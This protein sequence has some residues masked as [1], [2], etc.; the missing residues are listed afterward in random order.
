MIEKTAATAWKKNLGNLSNTSRGILEN[1][2]VLNYQKE[3][4]GL[5]K[6]SDNLVKKLGIRET[7]KPQ[8]IKDGISSYINRLNVDNKPGLIEQH[9]AGKL[10]N[11]TVLAGPKGKNIIAKGNAR[12]ARWMAEAENSM[13]MPG[14]RGSLERRH[15]DQ[16]IR[17]HEIDEAR[18]HR[19]LQNKGQYVK[20]DK[21]NDKNQREFMYHMS[22]EVINRESAN[23]AVAPKTTRDFFQNIR[24]ITGEPTQFKR[25]DP[26]F[27]YGKQGV[28][29][30]AQSN[31]MENTLMK[32]RGYK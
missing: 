1:K 4:Q 32:L 29:N 13:P 21:G 30:K 23:V 10:R 31:Q 28:F 17:R 25:L 19:R 3:F 22:P 18:V 11:R 26:N 14:K 16:I 6:G 15:A 2:G 7:N 12:D 8:R 5:R 20:T 27:E 9:S 24:G